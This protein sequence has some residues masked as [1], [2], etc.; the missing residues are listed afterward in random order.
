MTARAVHFLDLYGRAVFAEAVA[1]M[2]ARALV[3]VGA[4]ATLCDQRHRSRRIRPPVQLV[5]G[6]HIPDDFDAV[7]S[8]LDVYDDR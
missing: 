8:D 5:L 4:L 6:E 2:N 1:E 3:D 7:S